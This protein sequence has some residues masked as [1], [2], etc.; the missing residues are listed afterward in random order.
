MTREQFK[1]YWLTQH[2]KLEK[3]NVDKNWVKKIVASFALTTNHFRSRRLTG[4]SNC[5]STVSRT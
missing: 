3:E 5:T 1:D 2:S 4:W